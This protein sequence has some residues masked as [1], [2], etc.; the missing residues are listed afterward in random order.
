MNDRE[1]MSAVA[2]VGK[3]EKVTIVNRHGGTA[4]VLKSALP[5]WFALG[6]Q[7]WKLADVSTT[8][9]KGAK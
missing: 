7:G 1:N 5:K 9:G 8:S 3:P 4:T 6:G 2:P